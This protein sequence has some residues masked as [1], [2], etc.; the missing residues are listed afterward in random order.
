MNEITT[1]STEDELQARNLMDGF[2]RICAR[3]G[4]MMCEHGTRSSKLAKFH[5]R[6]TVTIVILN[7][8]T[9]ALL[10]GN[11]R[12]MYPSEINL[13]AGGLAAISAICTGLLLAF[14]Y[15]GRAGRHSELSTCYAALQLGCQADM[16]RFR[17]RRYT[18]EQFDTILVCN[19]G[20]LKELELRSYGLD[21]AC[22]LSSEK[23]GAAPRDEMIPRP[24]SKTSGDGSPCGEQSTRERSQKAPANPPMQPTGFAGG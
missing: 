22:V 19:V 20:I 7:V 21:R 23:A 18:P 12:D 16:D 2:Q 17:A 5:D 13:A 10:A 15:K 1:P 6:H 24:T 9:A 4:A 3:T 14:D 8:L 11:F